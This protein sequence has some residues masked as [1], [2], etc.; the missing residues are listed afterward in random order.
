M[1]EPQTTT[2]GQGIDCEREGRECVLRACEHDDDDGGER[3]G[4]GGKQLMRLPND[5]IM[6]V[7]IKQSH[8][9]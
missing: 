9:Y 1:W 3:G 5:P 2:E 4:G 7:L 6:R 8:N